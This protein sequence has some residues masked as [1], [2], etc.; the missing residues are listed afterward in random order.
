MN[1]IPQFMTRYHNKI[2]DRIFNDKTANYEEKDEAIRKIY[3][4][5]TGYQLGILTEDEAMKMLVETSIDW[6][7]RGKE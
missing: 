6:N 1:K 2:F 4:A 5:T 3:K 7:A